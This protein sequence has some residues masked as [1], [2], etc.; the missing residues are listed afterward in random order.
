VRKAEG[1]NNLKDLGVDKTI[2][3]KSIFKKQN[4]VD[5]INLAQDR[6]KWRAVVNRL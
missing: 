1:K 6:D 4:G 2:I 5:W 3:L